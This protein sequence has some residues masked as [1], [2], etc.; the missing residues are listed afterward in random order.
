MGPILKAENEFVAKF[1]QDIDENVLLQVYLVTS[2]AI[3]GESFIRF[4]VRLS[5]CLLNFSRFT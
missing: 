5:I 4:G 2:T 1:F 3:D